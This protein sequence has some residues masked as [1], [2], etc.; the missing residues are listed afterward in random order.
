MTNNPR[1]NEGG[2][3]HVFGARLNRILH[4]GKFR[5][6]GVE[7]RLAGLNLLS[8]GGSAPYTRSY[9]S[10]AAKIDSSRKSGSSPGLTTTFRPRRLRE[11]YQRSCAAHDIRLDIPHTKFRVGIRQFCVR[12]LAV[13]NT[14]Q[15]HGGRKAERSEG[16]GPEHNERLTSAS[17]GPSPIVLRPR[18]DIRVGE[19][20]ESVQAGGR[21]L[22]EQ[23]RKIWDENSR[24]DEITRTSNETQ[25]SE[26]GCKRV[27][28]PHEPAIR[29]LAIGPPVSSRVPLAFF[30]GQPVHRVARELKRKCREGSRVRFTTYG[31]NMKTRMDPRGR[32]VWD[33]GVGSNTRG[34]SS[35]PDSGVL[36]GKNRLSSALCQFPGTGTLKGPFESQSITSACTQNSGSAT[37]SL[38]AYA[39]TNWPIPSVI[40]PGWST[41]R[42]HWDYLL[43]LFALSPYFLRLPQIEIL[44]NVK[45]AIPGQVRPIIYSYVRECVLLWNE[46]PQDPDEPPDAVPDGAGHVF[47]LNCRTFELYTYDATRAKHAPDPVEEIVLLVA[48]APTSEGVPMLKLSPDPE[49]EA[50]LTEEELKAD[51]RELADLRAAGSPESLEQEGLDK[52]ARQD[53]GTP[54]ICKGNTQSIEEDVDGIVWPWVK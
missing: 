1:H 51:A 6:R 15:S 48:A 16:T 38:L 11:Q 12:C 4:R 5:I 17:S 10:L 34:R 45:Y 49:G 25:I 46:I 53:V 31:E 33:D 30:S 9:L 14:K 29:Y 35:T 40:H 3:E 37:A 22:G 52:D 42:K 43:M 41:S 36:A 24:V 32:S 26:P 28:Q 2:L 8:E 47:L 7:L 23:E 18:C 44:V 13:N 39:A 50:A 27:T 21:K 19:E 20:N 54:G